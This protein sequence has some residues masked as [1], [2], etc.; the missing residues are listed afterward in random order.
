MVTTKSKIPE[1]EPAEPDDPR[2]VTLMNGGL[3]EAEARKV[4]SDVNRMWE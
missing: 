2:I 4:I 3:T 1:P